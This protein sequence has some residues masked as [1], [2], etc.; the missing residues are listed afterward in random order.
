MSHLQTLCAGACG[1][2]ALALGLLAPA[3][4]AAGCSAPDPS[5]TP[6]P[7]G[8]LPG[9]HQTLAE[10]FTSSGAPT[11]TRWHVYRGHPS[12]DPGGT[13]DPSHMW[14]TGGQLV[15]DA[16][17]DPAD[18][19][20]WASGGMI[21]APALAQT[22]GKYEVRFKMSSG[23]GIA[24]TIMLW[25]TSNVW[26]PE[27]DFSED[28]GAPSRTQDLATLHYGPSNTKLTDLTT[29]NLTQWHTLGVEWTP[30][31]LVYTLDG[32]DW[33]T[34]TNANVPDV[35]MSLALQ[36]QAWSCGINAWEY[37]PSATTPG[38]VTMD[39][40]WIVSWSPD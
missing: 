18:G 26:P 10:D 14:V 21:E 33:A 29:V 17:Q 19:G 22:Y 28:N 25:P 11:P 8:D 3:A 23:L 27:I 15:I 16:F 12:G 13:W 35:P 30:G 5:C 6:M 31:R 32:T 20:A 9:W 1:A 39:V 37:C 38:H 7:V 24:H 4:R 36:T 40:D 34:V 2:G